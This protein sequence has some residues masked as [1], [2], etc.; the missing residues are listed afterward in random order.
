[1][2]LMTSQ[3]N[4]GLGGAEVSEQE[5]ERL[6]TKAIARGALAGALRCMARA[7]PTAAR[8]LS[9]SAAFYSNEAARLLDQ[10]A[11]GA[12]DVGSVLRS[13]PY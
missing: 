9:K 2:S 11:S 10:W 13:D 5:R 3:M 7:E 8:G 1:M 12:V 6:M 4:G